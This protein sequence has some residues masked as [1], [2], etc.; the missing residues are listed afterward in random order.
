MDAIVTITIMKDKKTIRTVE[1][2]FPVPDAI[3]E[4]EINARV[5]LFNAREWRE[6]PVVDEKPVAKKATK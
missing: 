3:L 2:A 6:I 5:I 1:S 4:S